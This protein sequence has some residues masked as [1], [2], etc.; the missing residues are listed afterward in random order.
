MIATIQEEIPE[1]SVEDLHQGS[2]HHQIDIMM[3]DSAEDHHQHTISED[4]QEDIVY[5]HLTTKEAAS[6]IGKMVTSK[7]QKDQ[8]TTL[9]TVSSAWIKLETSLWRR[10]ETSRRIA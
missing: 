3:E 6:E 7:C 4:L 9:E 2:D 1:V 5:H 10:S 8:A